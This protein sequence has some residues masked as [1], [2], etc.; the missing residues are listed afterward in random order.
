MAAETR[1]AVLEARQNEAR[2]IDLKSI[3]K[4][5]SFDG[6]ASGFRNFRFQFTAYCGAVDADM[7]REMEEASRSEVLKLPCSM[8]QGEASWSRQ[9][10]YMFVLSR[11]GGAMEVMENMPDG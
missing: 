10:D 5:A 11:V 4:L 2:A 9:L 1:G 8:R 7:R 3:C 6:Q